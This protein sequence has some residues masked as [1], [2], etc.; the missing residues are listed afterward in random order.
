MIAE[1][2]CGRQGQMSQLRELVGGGLRNGRLV[3][4]MDDDERMQGCFD[5]AVTIRFAIV[6]APLSM[7]LL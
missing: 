5:S 7:T 2:D 3:V 4:L 1:Q 6:A